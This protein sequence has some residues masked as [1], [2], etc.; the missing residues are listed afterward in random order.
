MGSGEHVNR[1]KGSIKCWDI[2]EQ[3]SDWRLLEEDSEP[4]DYLML[5]KW[6]EPS[7]SGYDMTRTFLL[8]YVTKYCFYLFESPFICKLYKCIG[9]TRR[10]G[11]TIIHNKSNIAFCLDFAPFCECF[12]YSSILKMEALS[13]SETLVNFYSDMASHIPGAS[14]L[15][16]VFFFCLNP[17]L[18]ASCTDTFSKWCK[19]TRGMK[20]S[21][22]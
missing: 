22:Q 20:R 13:S 3:L 16:F 9:S 11:I 21:A 15:Y 12:S 2:L 18:F 10:Y 8:N 6:K 4:W 17:L 1:L 5:W 19:I 7:N 14:N